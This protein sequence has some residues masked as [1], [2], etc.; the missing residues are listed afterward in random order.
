[1]KQPR[2]TLFWRTS[3]TTPGASYSLGFSR[4][5]AH[6][7]SIMQNT[8]EG[9]RWLLR[10]TLGATAVSRSRSGQKLIRSSEIRESSGQ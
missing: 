8:A 3:A 10:S 6:K 2:R 9:F 4:G 1:M 5:V 7:I